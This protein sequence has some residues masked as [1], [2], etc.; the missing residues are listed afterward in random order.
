MS[1]AEI[2]EEL[3]RLTEA[4]RRA[5]RQRLLDIANQDD[6]VRS[7]N[8]AALEGAMMLDRM[9]DEDASRNARGSLGD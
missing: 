8:H 1:V 2:M 9:E 4:D 3:P 5:V 7:C 6:D